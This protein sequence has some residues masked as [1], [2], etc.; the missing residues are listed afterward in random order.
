VMY[1]AVFSMS[2]SVFVSVISLSL[3]RM[4]YVIGFC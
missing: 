1:L 3:R 2:F 4:W